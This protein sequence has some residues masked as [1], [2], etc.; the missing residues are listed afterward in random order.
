L[1]GNHLVVVNHLMHHKE[2]RNFFGAF[3]RFLALL[4]FLS[5]A[6]A[7]GPAQKSKKARKA[8]KAGSGYE[9]RNAHE[10]VNDIVHMMVY[11][12]VQV[13]SSEVIQCLPESEAVRD[14][15][16]SINRREMSSANDCVQ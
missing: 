1:E 14:K 10:L 6:S 3:W 13:E 15:C 12:S 8:R 4:A 7:A 2:F 9:A 11:V 5:P 16:R